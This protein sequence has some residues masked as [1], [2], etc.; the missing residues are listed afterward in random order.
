MQSGAE[1]P[2]KRRKRKPKFG[3]TRQ[4]FALLREHLASGAASLADIARLVSDGL[5]ADAAVIYVARPGELLELA[6]TQGLNVNAVG[7][8]RL[9]AG[10]GIIG[11]VAASGDILNLA[12]AQNHPRYVYRAEI[13]EEAMA[14]MLAVPVKRAGRTLGVIAVM[15]REAR[16]YS[17]MEVEALATVSMLLAEI[18]AKAG[19][20]D[21]GEEGFSDTLP[22][23]YAGHVLSAGIARGQILPYGAPP[24]IGRLLTDDPDAEIKRLNVAVDAANKGLDKLFSAN[25]PGGAT[26]RDVLE[27]YRMVTQSSGWLTQIREAIE[28][29]LTAETAVDKVARNLR[30]RMR[31]IADP[32]LR[33]RLADIEDMV[34]RLMVALGGMA[35]KP[36]RADGYILLVRRLGPADLLDWHARGIAGVAIEEASASGH[37]AI[38]ARALGI[39]ALQVDRGAVE[40]AQEGDPAILD[41]E[42]ATLILRPE[43]AVTEVYD[44]ALE[45]RTMRAVALAA[46]RDRPTI[47]KDGTEIQLMLNV[48]LALELDQLERTG[49]DG[50]GLYRTEIAALAAGGIPDVAGQA[51][52]YG[53]VLDRANGKKVQFRT[54]DLGA[55][56][57]LPGEAGAGEENPAMG[58]R[59]LRVGLDRPAILRRQLRALLLG[60]Q[61]RKLSIMFPMVATVEEFRAARDLLE[62]ETARIRPAPEELE[63]GTMLEVPALLFQLPGLLAEADFISVGTN[64]LMQFLFAADRGTPELVDRYDTLS[65]PVL[66]LLEKLVTACQ[67]AGVAL[68]V[69]GEAA[70]RPLDALAFAALGIVCLSMSGNAILPVK[71]V[72]VEADLNALRPVLRELRRAGAAGGSIREPLAAWAREHNLAV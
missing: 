36:E 69:C 44:R 70:G 25:M 59:S 14:S 4:L 7:H 48:G 21:M 13:G 10:E 63:V 64:D 72:L 50:I 17:P 32:Y 24:P 60:A 39:P 62:A 33:E 71:A 45:A 67:E 11:M 35:P 47:T 8:T 49:A 53:R 29:G 22:R 9:R 34:G 2:P 61:G 54:L 28:D 6:A 1:T 51:A 23:R 38:L 18:L 66:E 12:D 31:R 15:S 58:W 55:D 43:P 37:A 41:A 20:T 65:A 40:T 19:A 52:E 57:L 5:L 68:S 27:A 3:D 46:Y 30:E 56:K 16:V 26:S 42:G